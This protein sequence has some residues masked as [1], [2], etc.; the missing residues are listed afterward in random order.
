MRHRLYYHIT[1]TTLYRQPL[2]NARCADFLCRFLR[3][4]AIEERSR[5]LLIGVVSTH[6]HV[7]I[8]THPATVI[9]RL[10]QMLKG[11]SARSATGLGY[12]DPERPL[13]WAAGYNLNTLGYSQLE[14]VRNY[15]R[16]QPQHHPTEAIAGWAGDREET[17]WRSP[18]GLQ[19]PSRGFSP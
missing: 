15:L 2:I 1:W 6:I 11:K 16:N 4:I 5:I 19:G 3:P 9:P 12:A 8:T 14:I 10:V 7:L 17:E 13:R 18:S